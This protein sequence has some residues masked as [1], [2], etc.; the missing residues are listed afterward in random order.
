MKINNMSNALFALCYTVI[1][2]IIATYYWI[3]GN[4][5]GV[6]ETV[7]L[8]MQHEPEALFRLKPKLQEMLNVTNIKQ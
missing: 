2:G 1:T 8:I 7:K 5:R 6:S 3:E 4:K